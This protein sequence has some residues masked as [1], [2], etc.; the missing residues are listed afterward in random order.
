MPAS[1]VASLTPA[2]SGMTGTL[3]GASGET[4]VDI[5]GFRQLGGKRSVSPLF[6]HVERL[7]CRDQEKAGL[8]NPARLTKASHLSRR[9]TSSEITSSRAPSWSPWPRRP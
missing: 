7:G 5:K 6:V 3:V 4:E 1:A 9:I 2:I 8:D